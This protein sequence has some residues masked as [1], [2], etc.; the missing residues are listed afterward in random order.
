MDLG[1]F[2]VR[3]QGSGMVVVGPPTSEPLPGRVDATL[4]EIDL[5]VK[6]DAPA[7]LPALDLDAARWAV[8]LLYQACTLLAHRELGVEEIARRLAVPCPGDVALPA[9][10]YS[11]DLVLRH[12][13]QLID[14]ARGVAPSDPLH[15][16]MRRLAAAWPLSSVGVE[17]LPEVDASPLLPNDGLRRF[18]VDRLLRCGDGTRMRD[19]R[20]ALA[21][22]AAIGEHTD[23][24]RALF[25]IHDRSERSTET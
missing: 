5:A 24:A 23:L 14:L 16:W 3:L 15:E 4:R 1:E 7:G 25:P 12:L 18:Y 21:V 13:P 20:V 22:Q 2:V 9:T 19:P 10:H 11:V 8:A 6:L 17:D